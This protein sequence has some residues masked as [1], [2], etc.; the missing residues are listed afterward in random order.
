[1][2][3][4][5]KPHDKVFSMRYGWGTV[6]GIDE[7]CK[8]GLRYQYRSDDSINSLWFNDHGKLREDDLY[9]SIFWDVPPITV[10]KRPLPVD[11]PILVRDTDDEVWTKRHFKSHAKNGGVSAWDLGLTSFT[12]ENSYDFTYWKQWKLPDE[13]G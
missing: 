4:N 7:N 10:P 12:V 9:P 11:A 2:F 3:K 1:M 8:D 5:L 13:E 6:D